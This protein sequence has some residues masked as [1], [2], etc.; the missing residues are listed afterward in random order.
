MLKLTMWSQVV[1]SLISW[2]LRELTFCPDLAQ[3]TVASGTASARHLMLATSFPLSFTVADTEGRK[4]AV[5]P[6]K[7][8]RKAKLTATCKKKR[9]KK[10]E[11]C[12]GTGRFSLT[13]LNIKK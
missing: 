2:P 3:V 8:E 7:T 11:A 9:K 6:S 5:L 10:E 4:P 12:S 1:S 13:A